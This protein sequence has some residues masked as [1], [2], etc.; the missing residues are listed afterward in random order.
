MRPH[1]HEL[2]GL[3][4][5]RADPSTVNL[6]THGVPL[7]PERLDKPRERPEQVSVLHEVYSIGSVVSG[8]VRLAFVRGP[9]KICGLTPLDEKPRARQ[10]GNNRRSRKNPQ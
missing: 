5:H 6:L 8:K 1:C 3:L 10:Y 9:A 7:Q 4:E 2:R